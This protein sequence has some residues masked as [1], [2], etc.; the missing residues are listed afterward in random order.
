MKHFKF[1]GGGVASPCLLEVFSGFLAVGTLLLL[2]ACTTSIGISLSCKSGA[3]CTETGTVTWTQAPQS[4]NN[5]DASQLVTEFTTQN[6]TMDNGTY[7][8]TIEVYDGSNLVA[9]N[10]FNY[11]VNGGQ[12]TLADPSTVQSWL[13]AH[14]GDGDSVQI[15]APGLTYTVTN[16]NAQTG[17]VT[18]TDYYEGQQE[19][20]ATSSFSIGGGGGCKYNCQQKGPTSPPGSGN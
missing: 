9:S 7:P 20:S 14:D 8:V 5:I 6:V 3:G 15:N 12:A 18:A 13:D 17:Q 2:A 10:T 16:P 19:A 4:H 1:I 11:N